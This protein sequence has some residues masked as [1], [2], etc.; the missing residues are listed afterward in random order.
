M[1]QDCQLAFTDI[2]NAAFDIYIQKLGSVK[3]VIW[4]EMHSTHLLGLMDTH[5]AFWEENP[6]VNM[7]VWVS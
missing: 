6:N 2:N 1:C 3:C 5:K 4:K 7:F